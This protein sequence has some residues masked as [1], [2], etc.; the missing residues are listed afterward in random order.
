M[1]M[2]RISI[3]LIIVAVIVGLVGCAPAP[4]RY[5]LTISSTDGGSVI[6]PGDGSFTYNDGTVVNLVAVEAEQGYQF[7]T[8][9][10][11][12]DTIAN[13][14]AAITI[15]TMNGDYEITANFEE[16]PTIT[17]AVVGPMTEFQGEHQWWGAELARDEIN[18][19]GGV[20]IS[21]TNHKIQLVKVET[22]ELTEGEDGSTGLANLNAVIDD[23]DFVI[24]GLQ[25]EVVSV[26]REVAMDAQKIFMDCGAAHGAL[27]FWAVTDYEKYKYWFKVT[28]YNEPFSVNAVL[29]LSRTVGTVLK[30]K[31][32]DAGD[33][34][35]EDYGVPEDGKL[36][37]AILME[38]A[39]WCWGLVLAIQ[40]WA[41]S[42]GFNVVGTWGVSSTA[43]DISTE[44]SQIA[45]AKPHIILAGFSGSASHVY[46][47]Q[48][49]DL[50]VPA[51]TIGINVPGESKSHW[52]DTDGKCN[53]EIMLDL[54]AEG[55]QYTPK[56][57][58]F[59]DTFVTKTGEFPIWTA[60]TY[61]AIYQLKAAIE[62]TDS[63]DADDI[64]P[65]LE[66][67]AY[68]GVGGLYAYYP[69]PAVTVIAG[70]LYALS[71][72]QVKALYD[73][74]GYNKLYNQADWMCGF[75]SGV[76][77]PHFA[78]DIVYGPGYATG[79]GSQWQDGHKVGVW[80]MDLG[81]D[82]DVGWTDQYGCWN[83]E[84]PGTVDVVI[85]IEGFLTS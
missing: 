32:E 21:G 38:V 5:N 18:D 53:G 28:P 69:V 84:Y 15:I 49:Y 6:T 12:V 74:T 70:Q 40:K 41:P 31:L 71:E 23:V 30:Q 36:R 80:P 14:N 61:D 52:T 25:T 50:G 67:H 45:A 65:Y 33:A 73:L 2:A 55:L 47:A 4:T 62:A 64:I 58:A 57:T 72:A 59:F 75:A 17:F 13:V 42:Y 3:F 81:D 20:D 35:A 19:A 16:N 34:V 24:G 82:Y 44:L 76:Q 66:T 83:F 48:K 11:D 1:N 39:T 22:K 85:P 78:H 10:G 9:S 37:I 63:I 27:Q 8:W 77:Q 54:W 60:A 56:T 29:K 43:T 7:V 46:S 26:Y 51:M 79:I 68:A